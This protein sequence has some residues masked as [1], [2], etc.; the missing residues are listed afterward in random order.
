MDSVRVW[1]SS[2]YQQILFR[3]VILLTGFFSGITVLVW[4]PN[5]NSIFVGNSGRI[6]EVC[7]LKPT[8]PVIGV[9]PLPN[10]YKF[11]LFVT[12]FFLHLR[13]P[14]KNHLSLCKIFSQSLTVGLFEHYGAPSDSQHSQFQNEPKLKESV[15]NCIRCTLKKLELIHCN[16]LHKEFA[17]IFQF[18][19][20][21]GI[22]SQFRNHGQLV[23]HTN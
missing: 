2:Q 19:M 15:G 8:L 21:K 17:H 3:V 1:G 5:Q 18:R 11:K 7:I 14:R 10:F 6:V 4:Q 9:Q 12:Y 23:R 22:C 13:Q 20:G 16:Y